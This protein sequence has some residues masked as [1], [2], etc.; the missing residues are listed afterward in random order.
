MIDMNESKSGGPMILV[1]PT[2]KERNVLAA[3]S[4]ETFLKLREDLKKFLASP[5]A[6]YFETKEL[7]V[8]KIKE[9]AK[10]KKLE[11]LTVNLK[12]D[13]Q[14]GDIAGSKLLKFYNHLST[15]IGKLFDIKD[16]GFNYNDCEKEL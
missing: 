5:N 1:D 14:E 15:E 11:F 12:T 16:K 8:E 10:K 9:Q 6:K 4:K 3:L 7:D 13:R 2:Y